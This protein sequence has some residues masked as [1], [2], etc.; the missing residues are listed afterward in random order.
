MSSPPIFA[1]APIAVDRVDASHFSADGYRIT[2]PA[3]LLADLGV[4]QTVPVPVRPGGVQTAPAGAIQDPAGSAVGS[5]T[6]PAGSG[7]S[8]AIYA[9]FGDLHPVPAMPE[10]AAVFNSS[11]GPG[12]RVV[13][14]YSPHLRES[15]D[16]AAARARVIQDVAN[17][18]AN[19]IAAFDARSAD[20]GADGQ[21]L[22]LV[23]IAAKIFAGSFKDPALDHLHPSYTLVAVQL[24][25]ARAARVPKLAIWY[26]DPAVRAAADAVAI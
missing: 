2:D 18:Y 20:L 8:G 9:A 22:N 23:P 15:P 13:H 25:A 6:K 11:P 19:T 10:T 4:T 17:G 14:T 26:F 21:L 5:G 12:R 7:G 16:D 1:D 24:A 3:A